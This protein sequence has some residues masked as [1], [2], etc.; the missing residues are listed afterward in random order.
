MNTVQWEFSE[1]KNGSGWL[2]LIIQNMK[3]KREN[4]INKNENKMKI[5]WEIKKELFAEKKFLK[6]GTE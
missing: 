4:L 2:S 5:E 1:N 6:D 3:D